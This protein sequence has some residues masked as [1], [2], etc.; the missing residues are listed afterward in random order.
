MESI[1]LSLFDGKECIKCGWQ[2]LAHFGKDASK[3]DGLQ[4]RC[5]ACI[6]AYLRGRYHEDIDASREY[7]LEKY[8][9][10]PEIYKPIQ[11]KSQKRP[12]A[13]AQR[14]Q[15]Q[16]I[17]YQARKPILT[18]R[19]VK[20]KQQTTRRWAQEHKSKR[21]LNEQKRRALKQGSPTSYTLA[22]W[23]A[24]CVWFGDVCLACDIAGS[25]T[26]DHVRPLVL[27]G[28]NSIENL[29]PLCR[30]CNCIK[31]AKEIDYRDPDQLT[32]FLQSLGGT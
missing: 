3:K 23:S 32:A 13:L 30:S 10:K 12:K 26:V 31:N 25:L 27:G 5:K 24:L 21:I 19:Q 29:Q 18:P 17:R 7:C 2:P 4:T 16:K 8:H 15:Q 20:L 14:N 22:E 11:A 28:S 9:A 1:Q 6:N